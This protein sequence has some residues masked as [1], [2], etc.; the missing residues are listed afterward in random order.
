MSDAAAG[1][2]IIRAYVIGQTPRPDLTSGL[3]ARF[4]SAGVEIVG[5]LDPVPVDEI[6]TCAPGG[7][8]LETRLRDGTRVVVD[9]GF[10]EPL[11]QRAVEE[12]AEEVAAH[13]VLCA[14]PFPGLTAP[15]TASRP[16]APVVKPFEVAVEW[17]RHHGYRRLEILVPFEDQADPAS[18]KWTS[19]GFVCRAHVLGR[20]PAAKAIA[21]WVE[22]LVRGGDAD[23]IVFDYVG[24]PPEEVRGVAAR[25]ETPVV[26]LGLLAIDALEEILGAS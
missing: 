16:G 15:D 4:A 17:F 18:R 5:A 24:F 20:R 10:V 8:P 26:D 13:L 6:P 23:A 1:R 14:G 21:P 22:S 7:Y 19:A 9:A 11:L 2:P 12:G 25:V 3:L